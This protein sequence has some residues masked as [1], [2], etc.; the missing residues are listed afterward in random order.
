MSP[1][2]VPD[3]DRKHNKMSGVTVN[4]YKFTCDANRQRRS[5]R[6]PTIAAC[7]RLRNP[8]LPHLRA[9]LPKSKTEHKRRADRTTQT[10]GLPFGGET[11]HELVTPSV[12]IAVDVVS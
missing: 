1:V 12:V 3:K 9:S 11:K 2:D 8:S 10:L 7:T 4:S 6:P 5:L